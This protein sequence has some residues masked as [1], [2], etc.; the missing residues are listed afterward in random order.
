LPLDDLLTNVITSITIPPPLKE[1][2]LLWGGGK[3]IMRAARY[4][5][6]IDNGGTVTKAALY[7]ATGTEVA[8][9]SVKTEMFFPSPGFAERDAEELWTAS[10]RVVFQVIMKAGIDANEIAAVGVTGHGNGI[11]LVDAEGKPAYNGINSADSRASKY[12]EEWYHDGTFERVFPKTCQ[13]IWA[14][15]PV[16]LLSWF[17]D[18]MPEVIN[19]T[20]W[21]FMCKDYV[22]YRLT[23][24]AYAEL[25]DYSGTGPASAPVLQGSTRREN[26]RRS[27]EIFCVGAN[28][29][30]RSG[31]SHRSYRLRGI[32]SDGRGDVRRNRHRTFRLVSGGRFADGTRSPDG[33]SVRRKCGYLSEEI[34]TLPG[35]RDSNAERWGMRK[36]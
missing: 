28:V 18:R 27:C 24:E 32:G 29:C 9:S 26:R 16:A 4:L 36:Q 15:Q 7:D 3:H 12:V 21:V 14:A 11:Y 13:S 2:E 34:C 23:G 20:R 31:A 6:G 1:R 25:T 5:L 19:R 22:R 10:A 33:K 8:I 30:R 17:R 35:V